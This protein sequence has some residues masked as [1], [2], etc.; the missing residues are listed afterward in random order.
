MCRWGP[1]REKASA[2]LSDYYG[3]ALG[4]APKGASASLRELADL[5]RPTIEAAIRSTPTTPE[6]V[7]QAL[8][9]YR[10]VGMD[11]VIALPAIAEL[12]QV[13]RLAEVVDKITGL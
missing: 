12:E 11:E 13:D 6:A 7:Q 3:F 4:P 10:D 1:T 5:R 2:S 8:Q 9:A